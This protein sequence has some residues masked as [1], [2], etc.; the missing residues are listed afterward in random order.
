MEGASSSKVRRRAWLAV[1]SPLAVVDDVDV[2]H[3]DDDGD[4]L[5]VVEDANGGHGR[6]T[7]G[8]D[9]PTDERV[10]RLGARIR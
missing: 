9:A 3:L 8:G 4:V 5:R 1:A 2:A 7:Q 6:R 10:G